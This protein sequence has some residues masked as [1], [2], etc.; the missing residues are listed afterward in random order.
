MSFSPSPRYLLVTLLEDIEKKQ[1]ADSDAT[2]FASKVLPVPV[3]GRR[4][5]VSGQDQQKGESNAPMHRT[6]VSSL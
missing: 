2:A 6:S 4:R 3:L 5:C 1:K